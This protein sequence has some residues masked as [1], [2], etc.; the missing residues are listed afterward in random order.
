M[1]AAAAL[2]LRLALPRILS[3]YGT[4][5]ALAL[6]FVGFALASDA[7]LRAANLLN[8]LKQISFL[9][10]LGVG[11]TLALIAAELDLSFASVC[12]LCSVAVGGLVHSGYPIALAI[13]VG[14]ALGIAFGA[15]NG[16]LVTR[17]KIPSLIATLATG[18][19]AAGIAFGITGG[20]AYV[21][22][23]P[24]PFLAIARAEILGLPALLLWMAAVVLL[25]QFFVKSTTPGIHLVATGEAEEAARLTGIRTRAMKLLG[26]TLSGA[27]A[28]LTAVLLTSS[29]SSAGP[30]IASDFLMRAIA[31]VLLGMTTIEPGRPNVPGT[32]AG[33]LIIGVLT[34]GLTLVGAP[35]Y[36]QDIVLGLIIIIAVSASTYVPVFRSIRSQTLAR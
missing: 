9:A 11:F 5:F 12:S 27:A 36:V 18:S 8:I 3:L 14:L 6:L 19:I 17:L 4:L 16:A 15:L 28:G 35:Y 32:L 7:F 2:A 23:L 22:R 13:A 10:I 26:L 24:A 20:V 25:A 1:T 30:T 29:L 31:T 21:G 33:A 34:N